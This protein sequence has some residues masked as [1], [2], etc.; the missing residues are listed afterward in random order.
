MLGNLEY[1]FRPTVNER[2]GG[3]QLDHWAEFTK[4]NGDYFVELSIRLSNLHS[5]C[6]W[7]HAWQTAKVR[8]C[9]ASGVL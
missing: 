8:P 3:E 6:G 1:N 9:K 5:Y 2:R 4:R 7:S